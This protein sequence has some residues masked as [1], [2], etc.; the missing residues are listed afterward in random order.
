MVGRK[1]GAHIGSDVEDGVYGE[2]EYGK[3]DLAGEEPHKAHDQVLDVL[4]GSES[5]DTTLL[6]CPHAGA[7]GLVDDNAVCDACRQEGGAVGEGRPSRVVVEGDVRQAVSQGSEQQ[8]NVSGEPSKLQSL[9]E[10]SKAL[11]QRH[12][13][14]RWRGHCVYFG[15]CRVGYVMGSDADIGSGTSVTV[16]SACGE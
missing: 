11:A 1:V 9:G 4:I 14:G 16:L 3:G 15:Y 5:D 10:G 6:A 13:G 2:G 7:V 8:R 12:R